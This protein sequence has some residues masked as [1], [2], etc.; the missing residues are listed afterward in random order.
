MPT[1]EM[2]KL[3]QEREWGQLIAQTAQ[4]DQTALARRYAE[5]EAIRQRFAG[6]KTTAAATKGQ[7]NARFE[8]LGFRRASTL[9]E[10]TR[11]LLLSANEGEMI[12]PTLTGTG[13]ELYAVCGRRA[14]KIDESKRQ[15]A[16]NELQLK[17][18][19]RLAVRHLA[20]LRK[21]ALI[22]IK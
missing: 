1:L 3:S 17:E 16:E 6:C 15:A 7:A 10:P 5:A 20:D 12:P 13:A 21:D 11:S 9:S 4:G 2:D 14:P 18:F 19:E 22:E 8:D